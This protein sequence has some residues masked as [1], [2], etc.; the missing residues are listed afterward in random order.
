MFYEQ[1]QIAKNLG[2]SM[3]SL[4]RILN[5]ANFETSENYKLINNKRHYD[6]DRILKLIRS[7]VDLWPPPK[8]NCG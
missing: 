5:A 8:V 7:N 3:K 1:T 4:H 6:Y 2:I